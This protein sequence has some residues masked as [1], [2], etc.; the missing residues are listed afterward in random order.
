MAS[1]AARIFSGVSLSSVGSIAVVPNRRCAA[2]M[3]AIPRGLGS[4]LNSTSPPPFTW[5]SMNPGTSQAPGGKGR[6]EIA[7]GNFVPA[8]DGADARIF[9][10]HRAIVAQYRAVKDV[11]GGDRELHIAL[12]LNSQNA[13]CP[14]PSRTDGNRTSQ[15]PL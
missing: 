5:V 11:V 9:D 12:T 1:R 4:S 14:E 7:A 2:A 6:L 10:H 3:A 8:H 13:T 15:P